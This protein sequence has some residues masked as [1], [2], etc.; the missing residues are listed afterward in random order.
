MSAYIIAEVEWTEADCIEEYSQLAYPTVIAAGG[1]FLA[2]GPA[3]ALEGG[4]QPNLLVVIEFP[5][6]E[7]ATTWLESPEYRPARQVRLK[8]AKTNMILLE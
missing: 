8:S 6:A 4:W 3:K 7:A 2:A 5:T 1:R